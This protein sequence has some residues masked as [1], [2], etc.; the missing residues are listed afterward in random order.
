[1]KKIYMVLIFI[2]LFSFSFLMTFSFISNSRTESK[3]L[4][5]SSGASTGSI[6]YPTLVKNEIPISSGDYDPIDISN[7]KS[8]TFVVCK[9]NVPVYSDLGIN[10]NN[11]MGENY[12]SK[13][14]LVK[15]RDLREGKW[16]LVMVDP[17]II[18]IE[19]TNLCRWN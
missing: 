12:F 2:L 11:R 15:M 13:G 8:G 9:D 7:M 10:E 3:E 4:N 14:V 16:A 6:S 17:T 1:M 18:Y 5:S 19:M